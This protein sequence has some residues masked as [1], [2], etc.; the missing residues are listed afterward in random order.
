MANRSYLYSSN[1]KPTAGVAA[2]E[3]KLVGI[4]EWNYDIPL[5]YRLLLSG[6]TEVCHTSIWDTDEKIAI[7]GNY[8]KGFDALEKFLLQIKDPMAQELIQEALTFLV[9]ENNRNKFFVLECGEIYEMGG[10][11]FLSQNMSLFEEIKSD[12]ADDAEQALEMLNKVREAQEAPPVQE[13]Q[14]LWN[15]LF[16]SK[17]KQP[18][19]AS[20]NTQADPMQEYYELGLGNWS[21]ILYFS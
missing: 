13:S 20:Q 5:V 1:I 14:S 15:K 12:V 16:G 21:N 4:S 6:D 9:D 11:D 18:S 7:L 17:K 19:L 8:D 2:S 10:D 3:K